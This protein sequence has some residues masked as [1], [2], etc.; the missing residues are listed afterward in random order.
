MS[1]ES[2]QE[3]FCRVADRDRSRPAIEAGE[4][5]LTYG[6]VEDR[7][8]NLANLLAG[9]G[10]EKGDLVGILA[11]DPVDVVIS[12][13]ACLK[14]GLVF[15]PLD[16]RVPVPRLAL[17]LEEVAP[18]RLLVESGFAALAGNGVEVFLLEQGLVAGET[19]W[20]PERRLEPAEPDQMCYVYFTSGSTGRPKG[21]AGRLK[22]IDH[23]IRWQMDT[24]EVGEG[25]RVSQ[26]TN[27]AFDASLRDFFLPLCAG[28]T[29]CAP[30][31]RDLILDPGRLSRWLDEQR[32]EVVHCVPSLFRA[33]LN[34]GLDPERFSALRLVFLA[35]EP[36]LPSDVARWSE[37]YGDRIRLINLY[38]PS[39]TTM[40]KLF[41]CVEAAD[42]ERRFIP[43]GKPMR[44]A[45]AVVVDAKNRA[46][47]PGQ[48]GEILIRTPFR[49]LG[50]F[51]R[52]DLTREVFV[53]SP[54]S[55]NPDD[56]VYRTGDLGRLL[57]DG[58]LEFLG[59][60]DHQVK[61]RGAR[62]ELAEVEDRLRAHPA[63]QD[64]VVVDRDDA[65][66]NKFLC[67]YVVLREKVDP[68]ALRE[69][70]AVHLPEVAIP[71]SFVVLDE[72][73]RTISGKVDRR[74]LPAPVT[75]RRGADGEAGPRNAVEELLASLWA[76]VL[77]AD[78]I[79]IHDHFFA[80]GGHSLL[81][82]QVLS[83][84]RRVFGVEV[85]LRSFFAAPT[86]AGLAR[87]IAG[88]GR[89][90]GAEAEPL[91]RVPREGRLPL[92]FAQE[93]LWFLDRLAPG[94]AAYNLGAA[95]R[96]E[97]DLSGP[98]LSRA[99]TEMARRHESL[100]T[101]FRIEKG[102]PF[103]E[104]PPAA[105]VAMPVIDL[106]GLPAERRD[107]LARSLVSAVVRG[108]FDLAR[109]PLMR[110]AL[111]RLAGREHILVVAMHHIVTDGWSHEIFARELGH[112]YEAYSRGAEPSLP[113]LP[114][115]YADFAAW[116]RRRL[117]GD[118][119]E[120]LL[121]YW[122]Q[123]LGPSVPVL[124]LPVDR[125]RP[126]VQTT[127]GESRT[128]DLPEAL[129]GEL[130]RLSRKSDATLFMTLMA[131]FQILL[132]RYAGQ[133]DFCV[134]APIA[135]R[136][137][138]ET[139][140]L[141]GLFINTLVIR[142]SLSSAAGFP[143]LL[144]RVRETVLGAEAHQ[145]LPFEKLVEELHPQ[146]DLQH[147][148]LFQVMLILQNAPRSELRLPGLELRS[149]PA[150]SGGAK[151]DLTL[152]MTEAGGRL[153]GYLEYNADLFDAA[154]MA[155]MLG[156][157]ETLLGGIAA[158]PESELR[159]LPLLGEA[160]R[161]QLRS[162]W[163]DT[164]ATWPAADRLHTLFEE[165]VREFPDAPALVFE[166]RTLTYGEL[167]S[168]A[169]RLA[170]HLRA[171]GIGPDVPV[172]LSLE[173]SAD[174][175]VSLLG[176]LKAGGAYLPLDPHYP[177]QRLA[178]ML[179]D[180]GAP[181]LL[182]Q[183]S[184]RERFAGS[185]VRVL[186]LESLPVESPEPAGVEV[187][188]ENLA[189]VLYTSGSTGRPKGVG[190]PHRAVTNFLRSMAGRLELGRSD[191]LLAV[192]S[193]SFDIAGLEIFLPLAVGGSVEIASRETTLD[194]RQLR[195]RLEEGGPTRGTTVLQST[196]STWRMLLEAGWSGDGVQV[197]CGGEP[198]PRKLA[199]DLAG[200]RAWN[201][202]GPTET[203]IWSTVA[204]ITSGGPGEPVP[205][206]RPIDNTTV[207]LLDRD[208]NPVPRG[209]AGEVFL[210]GLGVARGY[211]GRPDLT[212][213]RFVPSP[214]PA[215]EGERLYRTG[216][217]ARHGPDGEL[218]F[219]GRIDGLVKLRGFRIE[220]GEIEALLERIPG[221]RQAVVV[222]REDVPG[223]RRL[224]AYLTPGEGGVPRVGDLLA[225]LKQDLPE[226]MLPSGFVTLEA[227]PLTPNGKVDRRA[228]PAPEGARPDLGTAYVAPRGAIERTMAEIWRDVLR[229]EK[230][231]AHDN[232]F[233][234]GGQSLL[235]IQVHA[236]LSEELGQDLSLIELFQ[237]PTLASLSAHLARRGDDQLA[238]AREEKHI[239]GLLAGRERLSRRRAGGA[240][241]A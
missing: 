23:F 126:P 176:I 132:S 113:E 168:A 58:N 196:P 223:D 202:Y 32:V 142:A 119:L 185:G 165:R 235:L 48:I 19:S 86:I 98:S 143:A 204:P 134:G 74:A 219:L 52:P 206:G 78:R 192:T 106:G 89:I 153:Q 16:P 217:L 190:I 210:G 213:E 169:N 3:L 64:Q 147:S 174:L 208:L 43:I 231:G 71:T 117:Q 39:E 5:R 233:D 209:A 149:L 234:L 46:C 218:Q 75:A 164:A 232:F 158:Q 222:L 151:F 170:R 45:R 175:V 33:L 62:I 193:L 121:G 116:Q 152:G 225:A 137:R 177:V 53:Q 135:G 181:L 17:L 18:R 26:L 6:E 12:I 100:R 178:F 20:N 148:P 102:Q 95:L 214:F 200:R 215:R 68:G 163:A 42:R 212:A 69:F 207:L 199:N 94:S 54:F 220:T 55:D 240:M 103:Q 114:I 133:E 139:E 24:F 51:N 21:I 13:L 41:H 228:L 230:V 22:A 237:Y 11:E 107:G 47:A 180:S 195:A 211:L 179:E 136:T 183:E 30:P 112:L 227:F 156:H 162:G 172:G 108:P 111:L 99:L 229:V 88:E 138:L 128:F 236:R 125:P 127:R 38:G 8:N 198:L 85:S 40:V 2:V 155:R 221:V 161:E 34:D 201:L 79:G 203:T 1:F 109:G 166:E 36:L 27:P 216:D 186:T 159:D 9:S 130:A 97:G 72:L 171:Q 101:V 150:E 144:A 90:E 118:Y 73:P 238:Q 188:A 80:I 29:I 224:V 160:E 141:I 140:G 167:D 110:A 57:A 61:I 76:E 25:T 146:R 182:T 60:K 10:V 37:V 31:D 63:V 92:S 66:G 145:E 87:R 35:G 205:I 115:Q 93:R 105:P 129:S 84:V 131:A 96:L 28:G 189:Y 14:A 191:R 123:Q 50:Y 120:T 81:A 104:I 239:V 59:R 197:L 122:R 241:E 91:E 124:G 154:G 157:F 4:L 187:D 44:G 83:R 70:L 56:I 15:V 77:R 49:S 7:S 226:Y 65:A 173:R 82:T 67:A 194:G 184:L